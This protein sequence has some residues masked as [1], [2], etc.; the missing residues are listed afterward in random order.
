MVDITDQ[1]SAG[2]WRELLAGAGLKTARITGSGI[3]NDA[4]SD[5][6][7]REPGG[8]SR[9]TEAGVRRLGPGRLRQ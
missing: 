5:E 4:A 1:E 8:E 9:W 2:R 6:T 3:F 7:L